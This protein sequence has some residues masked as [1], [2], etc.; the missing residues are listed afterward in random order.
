MFSDHSLHVAGSFFI[1]KACVAT[2]YILYSSA[3]LSTGFSC[4]HNSPQFPQRKK[5]QKHDHTIA[6]CIVCGAHR[7]D[8]LTCLGPSGET[9][10]Y[11]TTHRPPIF[12]LSPQTPPHPLITC[13]QTI[14]MKKQKSF[15]GLLFLLVS[16]W[17]VATT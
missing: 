5:G 13:K 16:L 9:L 3:C 7:L 6:S 17:S 11:H 4:A 14:P 8:F 15:S 10:P 2:I 12:P 1:S